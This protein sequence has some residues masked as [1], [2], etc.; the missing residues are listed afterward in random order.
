MGF[1]ARVLDRPSTIVLVI[2]IA[3]CALVAACSRPDAEKE[4]RATVARM[5]E[6]IEQQRMGDFLERMSDDFTRE[7]GS[8]GKEDARRILAGAMLRNEK[9]RLGTAVTDVRIDG[10]R[11]LVK[12]RVVATGGSGM[13][14][15][16]GQA[17]EFE[18][19]WRREKGQ[20]KVF[21]AEWREGL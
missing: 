11:A 8:F 16:S 6:S 20:W 2:W 10:D 1:D 14:P 9:I 3:A 17:W 13:L 21:N 4:L 18:S 7:S 5:A 15:E 12:L 19:A